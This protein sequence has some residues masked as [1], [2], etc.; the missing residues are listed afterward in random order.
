[1][2]CAPWFVLLLVGCLEAE[3]AGKDDPTD[4]TGVDR[5]TD[6]TGGDDTG[7]D[8]T[9]GDDTWDG[10]VRCGVTSGT[11]G[12]WAWRDAGDPYGTDAVVGDTAAEDAMV[13]DL[14]A[15]DVDR[16]YGSYGDR[17]VTEP[18]VIADWNVKL[19]AAG[20]ESHVLMGDPAWISSR[21]WASMESRILTRLVDYNESRTDPAERF[22]GLHLDIEPHTV[23]T[24]TGGT[25]AD[26]YQYLLLLAH[27]YSFADGVIESGSGA[28]LP[29]GADLPVWYDKLPASLGGTGQVGWP[30]AADRDAW[31]VGIGAHVDRISMMAYESDDDATILAR[32]ADE[33]ALFPGEVR[34]G[35][36]EEVGTT[37]P[38][39][40]DMFTMAD[41][42]E[43]AGRVVDLHSY[44]HIRAELP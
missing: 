37:W 26:R 39:I 33:T 15:W 38:A 5:P 31:F 44:S 35:L 41:T 10:G 11:R 4:D 3:P 12:V 9:G 20:I 7:G 1:M 32:V 22:D 17:A 28:G 16:V 19:H 21:E 6:D 23:S 13:A 14:I 43:G 36:N 34:V 2:R 40:A 8:D 42:L 27:T 25:E 18:E 29:I 24:W 30:T